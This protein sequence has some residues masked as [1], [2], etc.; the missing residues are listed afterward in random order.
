MKREEKT[1]T[2][3]SAGPKSGLR[4]LK[5]LCTHVQAFGVVAMVK[6]EGKGCNARHCWQQLLLSVEL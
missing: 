6:D 3:S 4:F 5:K 2:Y 1:P